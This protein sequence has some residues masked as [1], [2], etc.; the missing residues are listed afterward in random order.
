ML[1]LIDW[2]AVCAF[3]R[4]WTAVLYL[5]SSIDVCCSS[6][7][8][9]PSIWATCDCVALICD[10]FGAGPERVVEVDVPVAPAPVETTVENREPRSPAMTAAR[11]TRFRLRT[12]FRQFTAPTWQSVTVARLQARHLGVSVGL[13]TEFACRSPFVTIDPVG[14][15]P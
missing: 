12:V 8:S 6:C 2:R 1:V 9:V 4:L 11:A 5:S 3:W 14:H 7:V 15:C 13:Q 10:W